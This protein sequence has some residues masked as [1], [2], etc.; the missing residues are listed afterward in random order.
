MRPRALVLSALSLGSGSGLRALY[1]ARALRRLGWDALLV[2]PRGGPLPYNGEIFTALPRHV[3]AACGRFDLAVG[4]KPY[5]DAWAG[6]ALARLLGATCVVDVDDDDGGYRGGLIGGLG[7]LIQAPAYALAHCASTH[8]PLLKERLVDR[9]GPGRVV[10]LAQG[11]DLDVFNAA[12]LRAGRKAWRR[13]LGWSDST[14]LAFT[15]HLNI[16]CQLD[17]LLDV[18]GPW[19]RA[20]PKAVLAVAGS[21]PMEGRF[22]RLASPLGGSVRFLGAVTPEGA[23]QCLAGSDC[24]VSAYGPSQGN[25]FRVPMKVAE[26]LA[27]GLPVVSNLVPGLEELKAFMHVSPLEPAAYGKALD[28]ALRHG[29][30]RAERGRT[31]VRR[32][33][34]WTLVAGRFLGQV[35]KRRTLPKG[36]GEA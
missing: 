22:R 2:H 23:A 7:G 6:L 11:V 13:N 9:L 30:A 12:A 5:P 29:R 34:D 20:H 4:V 36:G 24:L 17:L 3:A 32:R 31:W 14:V 18:L 35:R 27:M 28:G 8:H 19:L 10:D 1:L 33:L 25:R 16:A 15:A 26:S 21:G